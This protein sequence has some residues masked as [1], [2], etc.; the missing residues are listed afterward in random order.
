M[1]H[2]AGDRLQRP[3]APHVDLHY[4][5]LVGTGMAHHL[6]HLA[7]LHLDPL[8]FGKLDRLAHALL[9]LWF[10]GLRVTSGHPA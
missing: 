2:Q 4:V 3:L 1:G 9:L 6:Q 5:E 7:H 8:E 10:K